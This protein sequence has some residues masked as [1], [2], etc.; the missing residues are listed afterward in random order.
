MSLNQKF[1]I[2]KI[3]CS[4]STYSGPNRKC[5]QV[6]EKKLCAFPTNNALLI[7]FLLSSDAEILSI[8]TDGAHKPAPNV[9]KRVCIV[10]ISRLSFHFAYHCWWLGRYYLQ[11]GGQ[12]HPVGREK[13]IEIIHFCIP[14]LLV[15]FHKRERRNILKIVRK[16]S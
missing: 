10:Y 16:K 14:P 15:G 2:L 13:Y 5:H 6:C 11:F 4:T 7:C 8:S 9:Q 3:D 1:T 12:S